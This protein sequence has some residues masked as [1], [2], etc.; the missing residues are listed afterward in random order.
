MK[1]VLLPAIVVLGLSLAVA[2][3]AQ[4]AS[5]PKARQSAPAAKSATPARPRVSTVPIP[6][7]P[8]PPARPLPIVKDVFDFAAQH[9][10]V[11]SYVPCFCGCERSGHKHN[12]DCFVA[13]RDGKGNVT[14]WEMHGYT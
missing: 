9:P 7:V 10:E 11:L 14:G 13:S 3:E 8:Y 6:S 5:T 2:A 12:D 1:N 4:T